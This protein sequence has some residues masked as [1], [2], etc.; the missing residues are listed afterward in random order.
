ME[1]ENINELTNR[2]EACKR[3]KQ[4]ASVIR[5]LKINNYLK[6]DGISQE[7]KHAL[8]ILESNMDTIARQNGLQKLATELKTT[9]AARYDVVDSEENGTNSKQE[10]RPISDDDNNLG[11]NRDLEAYRGAVDA[12]TQA[13]KTGKISKAIRCQAQAKKYMNALD[14]DNQK[15]AIEY[16]RELFLGLNI[17]LTH[18]E[19]NVQKWKNRY[20]DCLR[21]EDFSNRVK[22]TKMIEQ[23]MKGCEKISGEKYAGSTD[24][25]V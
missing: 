2:E 3:V 24:R 12:E 8:S 10:R 9:I 16:K 13:L 22:I 1:H 17:S 7:D 21:P 18:A 20:Q 4:I 11:Y 25:S 19:D 5:K 14:P 23:M 6:I 15:R